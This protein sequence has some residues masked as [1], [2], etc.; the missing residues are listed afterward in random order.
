MIRIHFTAADF[1]RIRFAPRPAPLQELNAALMRM[2]RPDDALLFGR[3]RQGLLRTLPAAVE[4]LGDLVPGG[5]PP[6]FIDVFDDSLTEG[7]DTVRATRPEM[8]RT[9][10]E[11]VYA[12]HPAPRWIRDLHRGDADAWQVVRRAQHAAFETVLGPV[13]SLVQDL[14]HTEFTR[15]ALT[16]AEHGLGTTLAELVP[17][18]RLHDGVWEF[19]GAIDADI[20]LRGRG[21]LLLPTFHWSAHPL[22]SNLPERPVTVTYP[23][24]PGLPLTLA[25]PGGTED[26]L[27]AVI[28]RTR[29]DILHLLAAGH[30]TGGLAR[31]LR[32]G[33]ATISA[34][35]AALRGAGLIT[36]TRTGR[37]VRHERTAL[38]ALL[39][40]R[41][42]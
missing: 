28:G 24:G 13:W 31:R 12:G 16:M 26:A 11:R 42:T 2:V 8:V 14:H 6:M 36:T 33:N 29:L 5:R 19:A 23:A 41:H 22:V 3:W 35:T 32:V 1:A 18:S 20:E 9:E 7:L 4:P 15:H 38:G 34:H 21:L 30:T 17:G 37:S 27:A 39:V 40:G 25:G 10:I